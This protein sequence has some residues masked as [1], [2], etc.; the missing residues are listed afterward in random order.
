MS[1]VLPETALYLPV[2]LILEALGFTVKGELCGCDVVAGRAGE[3][4]L[5]VIAEPKLSF[6]L[7]LVL[8][9]VDRLR[10][11]DQVYFAVV[12]SRRGRDQDRRM[13]RLTPADRSVAMRSAWVVPS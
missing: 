7:E 1:V 10:A 4:P 3:P 5:M 2:K 12:A 9:A 8:Q 11:A 13:H 6:A